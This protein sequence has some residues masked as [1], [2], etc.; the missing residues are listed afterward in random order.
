M[1][2]TTITIGK[3]QN[4]NISSPACNSA[5]FSYNSVGKWMQLGIE[6]KTFW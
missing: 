6:K 5:C 3:I 4:I 1:C 2:E